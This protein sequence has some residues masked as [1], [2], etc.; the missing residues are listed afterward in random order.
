MYPRTERLKLKTKK[1]IK[2]NGGFCILKPSEAD[3]PG[4]HSPVGKEI[5]P[6]FPGRVLMGLEH[7]SRC[8]YH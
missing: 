1:R 2:I 4:N 8:S 3:P 6:S 7:P 5:T